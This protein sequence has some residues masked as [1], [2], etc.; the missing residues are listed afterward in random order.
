[1][2]TSEASTL[3]IPAA[4]S[5]TSRFAYNANTAPSKETSPMLPWY[6][7]G[8]VISFLSDK[9]TNFVCSDELFVEAS[10]KSITPVEPSAQASPLA[11]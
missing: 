9:S 2:Y 8:I 10:L 7:V 4:T 3:V 1:M 11:S 5:T 6:E